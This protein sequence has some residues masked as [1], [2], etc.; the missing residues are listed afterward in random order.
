MTT[1]TYYDMTEVIDT[2]SDI[3]YPYADEFDTEG[4]AREMTDFDEN[5]NLIADLDRNDFWGIAANYPADNSLTDEQVDYIENAGIGDII[6][7]GAQVKEAHRI[8]NLDHKTRNQLTAIRNA[9]VKH[10]GDLTSRAIA[11][12]DVAAYTR[13]NNNLSGL[14]AVIDEMVFSF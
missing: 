2:I 7:T 1:K 14:T 4:I 5:G 8:L 6:I 12:H 13:Y 3:L 10:L 9:I 11:E